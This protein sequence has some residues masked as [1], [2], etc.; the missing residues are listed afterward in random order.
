MQIVTTYI[1]NKL[2]KLK[3]QKQKEKWLSQLESSDT[4]ITGNWTC[5][6][7]VIKT[8]EPTS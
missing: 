5:T 2:H 1:K 4:A 8:C 7:R 6:T 3:Q